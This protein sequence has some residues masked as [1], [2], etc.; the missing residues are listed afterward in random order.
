MAK[1][2]RIIDRLR[3]LFPAENF[4]YDRRFRAWHGASFYVFGQS[5]DY[6]ES[7]G[8]HVVR[9]VRSDT[10]QIMTELGFRMERVE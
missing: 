8:T 3:A 7:R 9:Y 2:N 6:D 10:F 5:H 4:V 1:R